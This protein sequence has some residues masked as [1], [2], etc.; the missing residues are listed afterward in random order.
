M[1]CLFIAISI[2]LINNAVAQSRIDPK[3][4][5]IDNSK[6]DSIRFLVYANVLETILGKKRPHSLVVIY[7]RQ[8]DYYSISAENIYNVS[9]YITITDSLVIMDFENA[10]KQR[11]SFIPEIIIKDAESVSISDTEM[12]GYQSTYKTSRVFIQ[13]LEPIETWESLKVAYSLLNSKM[14]PI[15]NI[16][17][18]KLKCF[19]NTNLTIPVKVIIKEEGRVLL[20]YFFIKCKFD[21]NSNNFSFSRISSEEQYIF[22]P[23]CTN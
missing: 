22:N 2:F 15:S 13:L 4:A 17:M 10:I 20:K 12:L 18:N 6:C 8:S 5:G 21:I 14:F 19:N 3:F 9:K 11:Y 23:K 1:K 16:T 7:N